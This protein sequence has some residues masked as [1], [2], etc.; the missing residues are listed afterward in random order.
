[1]KVSSP[2]SHNDS[3]KRAD[4]CKVLFV[5]GFVVLQRARWTRHFVLL[6]PLP[7]TFG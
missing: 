3:T 2:E 5:V 1:M 4:L 6:L 7:L